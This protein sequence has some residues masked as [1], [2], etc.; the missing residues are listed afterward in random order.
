[1]PSPTA[2]Q[3]HIDRALTNVSVAYSNAD[4]IGPQVF[5]T[6]PVQKQSDKF[7]VFTKG[8]WFRDDA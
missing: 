7:F 3:S 5:P 4:Y 2:R 1:M 8:N 6:V